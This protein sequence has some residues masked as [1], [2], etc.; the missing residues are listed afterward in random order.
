LILPLLSLADDAD[1][2][3]PPRHITPYFAYAADA[4]TP[5]ATPLQYYADDI[6]PLAATFRQLIRRHITFAID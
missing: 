4:I 3:T 5:P 6:T 1:I 2:D